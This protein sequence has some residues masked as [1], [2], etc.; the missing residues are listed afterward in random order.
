MPVK[1]H[2]KI[3]YSL[4]GNDGFTQAEVVYRDGQM[5]E[6]EI[7]KR[8]WTFEELRTLLNFLNERVYRQERE[9]E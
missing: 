6:F 3:S 4:V 2:T 9:M 1:R 8:N 5:F 7:S